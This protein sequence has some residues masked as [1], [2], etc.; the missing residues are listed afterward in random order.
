M[1]W[2]LIV[3]LIYLSLIIIDVEYFF[4]GLLAILYLL[5]KNVHSS[6]LLIFKKLFYYKF[7]LFIFGCAGSVAV[8]AFSSCGKWGLLCSF[9]A[10]ASHCCGF[11]CCR[12]PAVGHAGLSSCDTWAQQ[13][14]L[15]GSRTQAQ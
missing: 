2:Y 9:G 3:V 10:P 4:M 7:Y 12:A 11:S 6:P 1:K 14:W 13:L 15:P 5:G 8:Q